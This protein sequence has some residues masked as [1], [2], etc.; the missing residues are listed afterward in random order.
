[1]KHTKNQT[2][3][4]ES[5]REKERKRES[6]KEKERKREIILWLPRVVSI[7]FPFIIAIYSKKKKQTKNSPLLIGSSFGIGTANFFR[8]NNP[9][10]GL[11]LCVVQMQ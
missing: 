3:A 9:K 5:E 10:Y 2:N 8:I 4:Q 11:V 7:V 1:M 6:E